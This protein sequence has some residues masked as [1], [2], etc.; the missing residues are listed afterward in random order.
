MVSRGASVTWIG[1]VPRCAVSIAITWQNE[2]RGYCAL[3]G[4]G[5][6]IALGNYEGGVSRG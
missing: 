4:L 1:A 3:G 5:G 2:R 6:I